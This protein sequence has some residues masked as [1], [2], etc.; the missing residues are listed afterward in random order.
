MSRKLFEQC[1]NL[2]FFGILKSELFYQKYTSLNQLKE[3]NINEYINY[4]NRIELS[5]I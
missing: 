1:Y 3:G 2:N 5:R 4:Y